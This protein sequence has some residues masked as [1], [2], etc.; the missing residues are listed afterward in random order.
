MKRLG[1]LLSGI[2]IGGVVAL[3]I[4]S[5]AQDNGSNPGSDTRTVTASG[6][7]HIR[8]N[9]DEAVVTL[10]VR[11]SAD[12]AQTAMDQNS[13]AMAEV[14][15]ALRALGLGDKDLATQSIDLSPRWDNR[16]QTVIGYEASNS[17]EVTIHDLNMVGKVIDTGVSSGAN[18]AGGIRFRVSDENQGL[19][20][21]LASAVSDAKAK[22]DAM[23][24]AADATVDQVLTITQGSGQGEPIYA[25]RVVGYAAA[26]LSVPIEA[27]TIDTQVDVTVTWELA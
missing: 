14:L 16:G 17:V 23:A 5:A 24:G 9:P 21:A 12:S 7:A 2:V 19:E 11:T 27:P 1:V 18:I 6:T 8:A 10:G 26:D 22:A 13:Q 15:D 4:P 25:Q 20:D 3:Q